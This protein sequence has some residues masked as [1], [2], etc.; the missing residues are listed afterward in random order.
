MLKEGLLDD[1]LTVYREM[2]YFTPWN[3][4]REI[5]DYYLEEVVGKYEQSACYCILLGLIYRT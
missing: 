3:R 1:R 5:Q 2:R 4:P